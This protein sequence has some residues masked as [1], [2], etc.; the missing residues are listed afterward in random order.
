MSLTVSVETLNLPESIISRLRGVGIRSVGGLCI[1][2]ASDLLH[3]GLSVGEVTEVQEAI[4]S[5]GLRLSKDMLDEWASQPES[6]PARSNED[7]FADAIERLA[8]AAERIA[9]LME[10]ANAQKPGVGH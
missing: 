2:T 1:L 10:K 9:I 3:L 8:D 6:A 7:R 4:H 5:R